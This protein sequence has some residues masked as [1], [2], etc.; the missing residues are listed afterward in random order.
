MTS[1][2]VLLS[3]LY[4]LLSSLLDLEITFLGTASCTPSLSRGVSCIAL[5]RDSDIWLFDCGESSQLQLQRSQIRSSKISKMFLTH[6]HGDHSFGLPGVLCMIGQST[7]DE[8]DKAV[9]NGEAPIVLDI[10]GPEGTRD[11]LRAAIQLTYSKVVAPHRIHELKNIPVFSY[12]RPVKRFGPRHTN[13]RTVSDPQYGEVE[14]GQDFY[15]DSNGVY[16]LLDNEELTVQAATMRHSIPCVGFVVTEKARPGKLKPETV[17]SAIQRNG[18]ALKAQLNIHDPMRTLRTLKDLPPGG[19]F[20]FPDGTVV[21]ADDILEPRLKGRKIVIM[22]DTN[23]GDYIFDIAQGADVL[24]HE[25]TNAWIRELD[26][27]RYPNYSSLERQTVQNGH[28]T[29]QMAGRFAH[30]IGAKRL[31]LTHFSPRYRGDPEEGYMRNMWRIENMARETSGLV[32]G[33]DV[34]AAWDSMIL[35]VP[36]LTDE[37]K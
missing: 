37:Y 15:P 12:N 19:S 17:M 7:A 25:A 23:T 10:Y 24:I 29:P 8:R 2:H 13:I 31:I 5:R 16:H 3:L 32:E 14:G 4:F 36:R 1:I 6:L 22:G 35:P 33:N 9:G 27:P 34:I 26:F 18:P 30:R 20:T 28:S 11:Y 21:Y